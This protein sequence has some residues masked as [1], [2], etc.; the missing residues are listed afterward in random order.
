MRHLAFC[1]VVCLLVARSVVAAV[2]VAPT[3]APIGG[4]VAIAGAGLGDPSIVVTFPA[5]GGGRIPARVQLRGATLVEFIVPY[6][7]ASGEVRLVRGAAMLDAFAFTVVPRTAVIKSATLAAASQAQDTFKQPWGLFVAAATGVTYIADSAHHQI[8]S[9]RPKGET[10]VIA[11]TGTPGYVDGAAAAQFHEPRAIVSDPDRG[12]TYVA[13]SGNHVI[14]L[15]SADGT[16]ST[17]AGSGRPEDRD[18]N[19]VQAGFKEPSGLAIDADGNL[20][21]ADSGNHRLKKITPDGIVTTIAGAGRSGFANGQAL[22]ALFSKPQGIALSPTGVIFVA[23]TGNHTIRKVENGVVS[24]YAGTGH[25]GGA[26]GEVLNSEFNQPIGIAFDGSGELFVADSGN[27]QIRRVA[28]GFVTTLA[29]TGTPGFVDGS[30]LTKVEYKQPSAIVVEGAIFIA[31]TMNDALRV[32][33]RAVALNDLYPRSG[34]PEGGETIRLFGDGFVPGQTQVTIGGTNAEVT[35]V[36][37]TELLVA[38]PPGTIGYADVVVSTPAGTARLERSFEY[39]PPFV[40]MKLSPASVT[41]FPGQ[42]QSMTAFGIATNGAETD[43][44]SRVLWASSNTDVVS[45]VSGNLTANAVGNATISASLGTLSAEV[46]VVVREPYIALAIAP[47]AATLQP[48]D[49]FQ[50]SAVATR[51]DGTS[52]DVTGQVTWTSSNPAVMSISPSGLVTAKLKGTAS[53]T[54][55]F[56]QLSDTISLSVGEPLPPDPSIVAPSLDQTIGTTTYEATRFLYEGASRIQTGVVAGAIEPQRVSVLRGRVVGR[57]GMAIGGVKVQV[58]GESQLGSTL[59]RADGAFDFAF[60]GGGA[61]VVQFEKAGLLPVERLVKSDWQDFEQVPDVVMLAVDD[62]GTRIEFP[63]STIQ[64][65]QATSVADADGQRRATLLIPSGTTATLVMP[66]GSQVAATSLTLRATEYSVGNDGPRAMPAPLPPQS[67]YTYCVELSADEATAA[68]AES[69]RFSKPVMQYVENFLAFPVGSIV[70]AGYYDRRKHAWLASENGRVI[71]II[72]INNALAELDLDG[73]GSAESPAVLA[74][75]GVTAEEQQQLAVLYQPGQS[76]WRVP[77]PHL[78]PWDYNWPYGPPSDAVGPAGG[79]EGGPNVQD[80]NCQYGSI[81]EC[82]NLT[83]GESL[84]ITGTPFTLQYRSSRT[85]GRTSANKLKIR[86]SGATVPASLRKMVA[87]IEVAGQVFRQEFSP[88]P[89]ATFTFE[90]NGRDAYGRKVQGAQ[91]AD[92]RIGYVY[93]VVYQTPAQLTASFAQFSGIPLSVARTRGEMTLWQEMKNVAQL[94]VFDAKALGLGGWSISA[95]HALIPASALVLFGDGRQRNVE[96]TA[97]ESMKVAGGG[98]ATN[99]APAIN[100]LTGGVAAMAYGSDGTLYLKSGFRILRIDPTGTIWHFAGTGTAGYSGDG[101]PAV[102]AQINPGVGKIAVGPDGSVYLA[103]L[104]NAR[105]RRIDRT[106]II[107]TIGGNGTQGEGGRMD[108]VPATQSRIQPGGIAVASDGTLYVGD[109]FS[110]RRISPDGI[111]TTIAGVGHSPVQEEQPSGSSGLQTALAWPEDLHLDSQGAL[112]VVDY[113]RVLRFG[114]DGRVSNIAGRYETSSPFTTGD[115]GPA[116]DALLQWPAGV[117]VAPDGSLLISQEGFLRLITPNGIIGRFAGGGATPGIVTGNLLGLSLPAT[118]AAL[119]PSTD[120]GVGLRFD[121]GNG[122]VIRLRPHIAGFSV[123]DVLVPDHDRNEV[124]RFDAFGRHLETI[125][126]DTRKALYRFEYGPGGLLNA[127]VDRYEN[128]TTIQRSG[129]VITITAPR[130]RRSVLTLDANGN[131]QTFRSPAGRETRF[132]TTSEGLMQTFRS[133]KGDETKFEYDS[134]GLLVRHDDAATGHRTLER[135]VDA[136]G[137]RVIIRTAMSRARQYV[138]QRV[139]ASVSASQAVIESDGTSTTTTVSS[140]YS[141]RTATAADGTQTNVSESADT[142]YGTNLPVFSSFLR[143]P[144]GRQRTWMG[145]RTFSGGT[146]LDPTNITQRVASVS[147]NGKR[148][149]TTYRLST[150]TVTTV[151]PAGRRLTALLD[152]NDQL[153]SLQ[154]EGLVPVTLGYDDFGRVESV[155]QDTRGAAFGY[156]AGDL[157]QTVTDALGHTSRYERDEDGLLTLMD[158]PGARRIT[159]VHDDNGQLLSLSPPSR[160][161]HIFTHTKIGLPSTYRSPVGGTVSLQ[162]N[163]DA[164]LTAYHR[165]DARS[166]TFSYDASDHLDA[167]QTSE[168]RYTMVYQPDGKLSSI[169]APGD[170]TLT[171]AWDGA[172]LTTLAWTGTV[173]GAVSVERDSDLRPAV[174]TVNGTTPVAFAYDNDDLMTGAGALTLNRDSRNGSLLGS[175][176]DTITD[177][178]SYNQFGEAA[179][180]SA[181]SSGLPLF[182]MIFTRDSGGRISQ[183]TETIGG[184]TTTRAYEYDGAGRIRA[185]TIGGVSVAE[186]SYDANGNRISYRGPGRSN[187]ATY[188]ID[189]RLQTYGDT[190]FAYS[191]DGELI[192][193]TVGGVTTTLIYDSASNLRR[194]SMPGRTIEYVL[195]GQHRRVAKRVNGQMTQRLLWSDQFQVLAELDGTGNVINRF[196]YAARHHVPDYFVRAGSVYRIIADHVGSPRLIV[197][198]ATGTIAQRMDYDEFGN[199][200]LDT[201]PGFQPFGFAGGLYD[202]DTGML[203]FGARDYDPLTGRW[204]TKDPLLFAGGDSNL[205][206]YVL[207]DPINHIDPTGLWIGVDEIVGAAI[208]GVINTGIYAVGQLIKYHGNVRCISGKDLAI[209]FGV[210]FVAGFF[211]TDTF[212][213]SVAVAASANTVQ[214]AAIEAAHGRPIEGTGLA[215]SAVAGALGGTVSAAVKGAAGNSLENI[216]RGPDRYFMRGSAVDAA[217]N[218]APRTAAEAYVTNGDATCGCQQ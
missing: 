89:N 7:A 18:G 101:G 12:R 34:N 151:T 83:L 150:R 170:V 75:F 2:T 214:Y 206:A 87:E 85:R 140:D 20:F 160:P 201:N 124:H 149:T 156:D 180:Y 127:I 27:H 77:I 57:D 218:S 144:S 188:D 91:P 148:Y 86:L 169:T 70:P 183:A 143:L 177:T 107:T 212:G 58:A 166:V 16:V 96:G 4:H 95:H 17:F 176:L 104:N 82:E 55:A 145:T 64:A 52:I 197:N 165:A 152:N 102:L 37:S 60:N 1:F 35:Y 132:T 114:A 88:A 21:V 41:L 215:S 213:A 56:R 184:V 39:V 122:L 47:R 120:L 93:P 193:K 139:S 44:T 135:S 178:W 119:S 36:D 105:V 182:S 159:L 204:T 8:R 22:S 78:T 51:F 92:V 164:E 187:T 207:Q 48:G 203:R 94:G 25:P 128:R 81:I 63:S 19:G 26:N 192:G 189:D 133:P 210:G 61:A 112:Y 100:A 42:Y 46:S 195:D 142:R 109:L 66:N 110:I 30:D 10:Q 199:V 29:G 136:N 15:L 208:G 67:G 181:T 103:D 216:A 90:W 116:N 146:A 211:A 200:L 162:Y 175:T 205:Y 126:A 72:A 196:V 161:A 38:T 3:H 129:D 190:T 6:G 106:G 97:P 186:Y 118:Y 9:V 50:L 45:V 158:L 65:A 121:T 157:V 11:G 49:T 80:P 147:V 174:E 209:A 71:R 73:D 24:T 167:V 13:D 191:D 111:V 123:K 202:R 154:T 131:L 53:I 113:G 185:V 138:R 217:V 173:S 5:E 79:V 141:S 179:S 14:R 134:H 31:D 54:A 172:A 137:A 84:P 33:Y 32:L 98:G 40:S 69:V 59:T 163:D 28:D 23:D 68:G 194:V 155:L 62:R 171:Y 130:G 74:T 198:A 115:G 76:L 108:G 168:G 99:G 153:A 43:I 125:D 117:L